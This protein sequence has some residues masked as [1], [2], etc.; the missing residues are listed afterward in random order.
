LF[1]DPKI[2]NTDSLELAFSI[3][4]YY[5]EINKVKIRDKFDKNFE[6]L[7]DPDNLLT[8][9]ACQYPTHDG[10]YFRYILFDITF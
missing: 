9:I 2:F 4:T 7:T 6:I 1:N 10:K 5:S 8:I 3:W